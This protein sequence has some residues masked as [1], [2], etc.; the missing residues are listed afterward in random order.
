MRVK[1]NNVYSVEED[2]ISIA[3]PESENSLVVKG[4]KKILKDYLKNSD[5]PPKKKEPKIL[6]SLQ[7]DG[8]YFFESELHSGNLK[9]KKNV[10]DKIQFSLF[11]VNKF[12]GNNMGDIE[13]EAFLK[14]DT[15]HFRTRESHIRFDFLSKTVKVT[16]E[17]S[18][19]LGG[20]GVEFDGIYHKEKSGKSALCK[21]L[22]LK[23]FSIK[24]HNN[25]ACSNKKKKSYHI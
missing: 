23:Y 10:E 4:I 14:N 17:T 9:I 3:K 22:F 16:T 11:V 13:G 8:E 12:G 6:D 19:P 24:A 1:S 21:S 5:K 20:M 18:V 7:I 2:H 15:A 25:V